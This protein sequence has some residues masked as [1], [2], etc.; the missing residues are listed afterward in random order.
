MAAAQSFRWKASRI[1]VWRTNI[2]LRLPMPPAPQL[3]LRVP[4]PSGSPSQEGP[5]QEGPSL[6]VLFGRRM[7]SLQQQSWSL[8]LR[9]LLL[10]LLDRLQP[11]IS[12]TTTVKTPAPSVWT[13]LRTVKR[14]V[15]FLV[16][17]SSI[18]IVSTH[19]WFARAQPAHSASL[20]VSLRLRKRRRAV[21]RMPTLSYLTID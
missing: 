21:A 12:T 16:T 7:R 4:I 15:R 9:P 11:P 18:A 20:T 3:Q 6:A 10:R 14:F 1:L 5:S 2:I 13:S 17:T 8:L 19:G